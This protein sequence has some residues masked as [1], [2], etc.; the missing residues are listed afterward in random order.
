M[1]KAERLEAYR[2]RLDGVPI[3]QIAQHF[4][5]SRQHLYDILPVAGKPV[6]GCIYPHINEWITDNDS[7]AQDLA[8]RIGVSYNSL[9]EFLKG[10]VASGKPTID[11]I[12]EVTGMTY[13]YAF[14]TEVSNGSAV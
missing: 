1:T 9:L 13:E 3:I 6:R 5:V 7:C 12:L 14:A 11:K 2:M 10:K 8:Q 4:G